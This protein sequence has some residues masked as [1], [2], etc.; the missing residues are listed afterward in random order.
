[1][2]LRAASNHHRLFGVLGACVGLA[3]TLGGCAHFPLNVPLA[4]YQEQA[5]YRLAAAP[6]PTAPNSP[7]L[8]VALSFS[9]GGTRAAAFA[10]GVLTALEAISMP[11]ADP[12]RTLLDEVDVISAVS[13]GGIVAAYYTLHGKR[14]FNDFEPRFLKRDVQ[15]EIA[16]RATSLRSW[17]RLASSRF[18]RIDLVAEYFDQELFDHKTFG[19][20]IGHHPLLLINATD[21]SQGS[22]FDFTQDRFDLLCSD[23]SRFPLARAVA[24]TAAVPV[25]LNPITI[26]NFGWAACNYQGPW[27]AALPRS[28]QLENLRSYRDA[29]VRR[30]LHLV[31]GGLVDNLGIQGLLDEVFSAEAPCER[32]AQLRLQNLRHVVVI[33]VN[34]VTE[35]DHSF[36]T[37]I[38]GPSLAQT[39]A[40]AINIPIDRS[41]ERIVETLRDKLTAWT[42]Q[43]AACRASDPAAGAAQDQ[44]PIAIHPV[45]IN[46][47]AISDPAR[48]AALQRLPTS[49]SLAPDQVDALRHAGEEAL[50]Q[51]GELRRFL[52]HLQ[53]E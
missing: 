52:R 48:R 16:R 8:L 7:E 43:V 38:K 17:F 35:L 36:D 15:G 13:G 44:P 29:A 46:F 4:V 26:E 19:D 34:A 10:Y 40:A 32:V 37:S 42:A 45:V 47:D 51:S 1:M 31:D 11:A 41:S 25:L 21:I 2:N 27:S 28:R 39:V 20:L 6:T 24:A 12:P 23:L 33:T 5:G 9:G 30:Y 49:F 53:Q 22:R 18:R 50:R 3:G 14:I